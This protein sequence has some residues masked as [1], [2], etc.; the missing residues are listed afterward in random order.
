MLCIAVSIFIILQ[1]TVLTISSND[2]I[3]LDQPDQKVLNYSEISI[4]QLSLQEIN[5]NLL[6]SIFYHNPKSIIYIIETNNSI[7]P[8]DEILYSS[9]IENSQRKELNYLEIQINFQNLPIDSSEFNYIP[10]SPC[11]SSN[12]F[13]LDAPLMGI[14]LTHRFII[15]TRFM[16]TIGESISIKGSLNPFAY[17]YY[18]LY[19]LNDSSIAI[20]L[21][22]R[23]KLKYSKEKDFDYFLACYSTHFASR[24]FGYISLIKITPLIRLI[25][26]N[27]LKNKVDI[28]RIWIKHKSRLIIDNNEINPNRIVC[29]V[30]TRDYLKCDENK[31]TIRDGNGNEIIWEN[32]Y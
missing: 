13:E 27:K 28:S 30:G 3:D 29:D 11:I 26:F 9:I 17:Y 23:S 16:T 8:I 22:E 5:E 24:L 6:S 1:F 7:V 31:G 20:N 2:V 14:A 4:Y 19:Y 25:N 12:S 21:Q 32:E 10:I 15:S 18:F